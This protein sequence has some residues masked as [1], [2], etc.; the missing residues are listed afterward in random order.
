MSPWDDPIIAQAMVMQQCPCS[1]RELSPTASPTI[2][3]LLSIPLFSACIPLH[4]SLLYRVFC[5]V[6]LTLLTF[7][8][9]SP[10]FFFWRDFNFK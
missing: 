1:H 8:L 5:H 4:V 9:H 7:L 6:P 3:L 10:P 2:S